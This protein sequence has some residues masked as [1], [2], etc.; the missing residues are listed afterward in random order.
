M[1]IILQA[2]VWKVIIGLTVSWPASDLPTYGPSRV[3]QRLSCNFQLLSLWNMVAQQAA[4]PSSTPARSQ[5][6]HEGPE[7]WSLFFSLCRT[8]NYPTLSC[9]PI[10]HIAS[11]HHQFE[12]SHATLHLHSFP[13]T[14]VYVFL[15]SFTLVS[16]TNTPLHLPFL[17]YPFP[18]SHPWLHPLLTTPSFFFVTPWTPHI[19]PW[20]QK[21]DEEGEKKERREWICVSGGEKCSVP[22][23][24]GPLRSTQG[25]FRLPWISFGEPLLSS[26]YGSCSKFVLH[27]VEA[28]RE[29][30]CVW[31]KD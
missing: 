4:C 18:L 15:P 13:L 27:W 26:G 22:L 23:E 8:S 5:R 10:H 29:C 3:G 9:I 2:T 6:E 31:R 16:F 11:I 12:W 20:P 14:L 24:L 25:L 19:L 1:H 28:L 21:S 30:P 7:K 17:P